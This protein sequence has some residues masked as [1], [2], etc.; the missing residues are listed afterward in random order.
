MNGLTPWL[1]RKVEEALEETIGCY[2]RVNHLVSLWQDERARGIGLRIIGAMGGVALELGSGPGNY[3]KPL[4]QRIGGPLICLD[5]S[6]EMLQASRERLRGLKTHLLR[7]V[8]EA[9][10]LRRGAFSLVVAAYALRDSTDRVRAL[11]EV[12]RILRIGGRLLLIDLGKPRNPVME[13]LLELHLRI[14]VP[15]IAAL[16]SNRGLR[17]PW[18]LLYETY[19]RLPR[20]DEL[21]QLLRGLIGRTAMWELAF[22]ALIVL[23]AERSEEQR[24]GEA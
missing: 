22:G 3:A 24:Q 18:R 4:A 19:R 21:L 14:G 10:P 20:N 9:L 11:Q 16:A 5:Y 17:N 8:F 6:P 15:L 13:R 1:W 23:L 12:R 7:G 2:E